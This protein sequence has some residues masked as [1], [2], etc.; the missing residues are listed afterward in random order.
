MTVTM[1]QLA[2]ECGFS[3]ATVSRALNNDSRV[4]DDTR[5]YI[6]EM[7]QRY[8]YR[9]HTV[10][11]NL[12]KR[13]TRIVGM[14]M[15]Q[16]PRGA[17]DP[18]FLEFLQGINETLFHSGYSLLIPQVPL[19]YMQQ[20]LDQMI[21]EHRVDGVILT[22][23]TQ[24]DERMPRLQ[25]EGIPFVLLGRTSQPDVYWVD[26]ENRQGARKAVEHLLDM[27]HRRIGVIEGEANQVAT[28]NRVRGYEEA[29]QDAG[30]NPH[31]DWRLNADYTRQGAYDAVSRW[32]D[33]RGH[34][35]VTALFACNDLMAIG[36]LQAMK[37]FGLRVPDDMGLV[38]FDGIEASSCVDPSLTTVQQPILQLGRTA[39][40]Q[41]LQLLQGQCPAH[42][43]IALPVSLVVRESSGAPR[44][45]LRSS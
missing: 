1:K 29:L 38:G 20:A 13:Q 30:V 15:P 6:Q 26:G 16:A 44:Q 32:L 23:P 12:A 41:L 27:G 18:F 14:L 34:R 33:Q 22:E 2:D 42:R 40:S 28:A 24:K 3:K 5:R 21:Y 8:N 31:G 37:D 39:S 11:S 19:Q 4:K 25:Q 45:S 35:R 43:Q 9:P 7:A 10:A 36:A 17:A